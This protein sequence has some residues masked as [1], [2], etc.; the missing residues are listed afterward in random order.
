MLASRI[1]AERYEIRRLLG[2]GGMGQVYLAFDQLLRRPVALK[3]FSL[4]SSPNAAEAFLREAR[5]AARLSH[6]NVVVVHD[7]GTADGHAFIA[8]EYVEGESLAELVEKP[9]PWPSVLGMAREVLKGLAYAHGRGVVHRDIKPSNLIRREDGRVVILDLG[10]SYAIEATTKTAPDGVMGTPAYMAPEQV[11]GEAIDGRADLFA[12]G[13][14]LYHLLSATSPFG[15]PGLS[16]TLAQVLHR[17]PPPPSAMQPIPQ[18]IDRFV[19]RLLAKSPSKRYRDADEALAA[20]ERCR[21]SELTVPVRPQSG[22]LGQSVSLVLS[23]GLAL[24]VLSSFVAVLLSAP[25]GRETP[26]PAPTPAASAPGTPGPSGALP[27]EGI[28]SP[29][30]KSEPTPVSTRPG[31]TA[32]AGGPF[33]GAASRAATSTPLPGSEPTPGAS[34]A[35]APGIEVVSL[36]TP[37]PTPQPAVAA[38]PTPAPTVAAEPA[39]G[40]LRLVADGRVRLFLDGKLLGVA[41]ER[42]LE[43]KPGRYRIE[44]V[45]LDGARRAEQRVTLEAGAEQ[46]VELLLRPVPPGF[47]RVKPP[48]R[49]FVS[50]YVD[51]APSPMAECPCGPLEL[52]P[53]RHRLRFF[54]PDAG[55]SR[56]VEVEVKSGETT[57]VELDE[58]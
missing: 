56:V 47:V 30:G 34:Q 1:I 19:L 5:L 25:G 40:R 17:I 54:N 7:V 22:R 16:E 4:G 20:L 10:I 12:L 23:A 35:A 37:A 42:E 55:Y 41:E 48:P 24:V 18:E 28:R 21:E 2:A 45:S 44:A 50:V 6:P 11:R 32:G 52:A 43:L 46:T 3:L 26:A 57:A 58:P 39:P 14:V 8:M 53:G 29:G 9:Q 33:A 49:M 36:R 38:E 51:D 13:A 27:L 31:T 15:A